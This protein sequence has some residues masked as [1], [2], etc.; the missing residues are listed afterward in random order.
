M[1]KTAD[2]YPGKQ[3][4]QIAMAVRWVEAFAEKGALWNIPA[5]TIQQFSNLAAEASELFNQAQDRKTRT[6]V[7]TA[8]STAALGR[9]ETA[10]RDVKK[11]YLYIPPLTEGD[12]ARLGLRLPDTKPTPSRVPSAQ[13]KMETFLEGRHE[14]GT[15]IVIVEGNSAD[16]AND[17]FRV[18]YMVRD[19]HESPPEHPSQLKESFFTRRKKGR[20]QFDP[21]DS[22]K[23]CHFAV[24]IENGD[25]KGPWGP[26]TSALIP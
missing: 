13:A 23:T 10:A 14:L 24:Q 6:L 2:W 12:F 17:G 15:R 7:I 25:K 4:D 3:A 9:V 8:D 11:R 18:H 19:A 1:K 26:M 21:A 16:P 5:K 22:G 20:M